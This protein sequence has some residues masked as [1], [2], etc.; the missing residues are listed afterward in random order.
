[1]NTIAKASALGPGQQAVDQAV[2]NIRQNRII[3]R[4]LA[5]DHTVWK[6]EPAEITNRLGWLDIAERMKAEISRLHSF[7]ESV[8]K[9]GYTHALLLGMGGSSLAPELFRKTFGVTT[10]F[11]DVSVLDSTDP[12]AVLRF[13]RTLQMS[14]TL[15]IVATK[16]GGTVET[17]S[18]FKYFYNRFSAELGEKAVGD[19]F[20]AITDPGSSLIDLG[21]KYHFRQTFLNDP[22]IGG[23]YSALSLFGLVPAALLGVDLNALLNNATMMAAACQTED[24]NPAAWLGA[25]MGELAK[26]GRDKLTFITSATIASFG[27]WAEQL[28]AESTGKQAKGILPVVGETVGSP[29]VYGP[30]RLF[31]HLRLKNDAANDAAV[32]KLR[33]AGHPVIRIDLDNV[34]DLAGQFF[35]WELATAVAGARLGINPF[36]QPNVEAAKILAREMVAAYLKA[37][38][39]PPQQPT[40]TGNGVEVFAQTGF[41]AKD[42]AAAL[43]EVIGQAQTGA[44]LALQAYVESTPET[45]ALL[46]QI[47]IN[48]RYSSKLATTLGYGPRF[49]HSTGQLHKGDAGKGIFIQFTAND[50]EDT[51]IPDD[52]GNEASRMSF[53]VLKLAQALGD[54]Q[55]LRDGGRQVIRLHL[56]DLK[57]GLMKLAEKL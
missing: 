12:G 28:V 19:H 56:T 27:D 23:R 24:D 32:Q 35:L 18:G 25:A 33:D 51:P 29:D 31:V 22:N 48:L 42:A 36:D 15:I 9:V 50:A 52:A 41:A 54:G 37:G 47:R 7:A 13:T 2:A 53:G 26:A 38:S 4:I 39:L 5:H 46:Q 34:Y 44:Y 8:C 11:L 3:Q 57:T 45:E 55:A 14:K 40:L 17:L 16:S 1:M 49:L 30:D 21:V 20:V 6:P 10:D 43:T